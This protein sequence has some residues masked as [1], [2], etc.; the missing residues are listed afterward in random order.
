[1]PNENAPPQDVEMRDG[2]AAADYNAST[3]KVLHGLEAVRKRPGMYIGDTDDGTGLH[4]MVFE[5]VDNAIDEALA[6]WCD[7]IGLTI[8]EDGSITV[9]DNGRGIP[10]D[11]NEA[12]QK[13]GV[14]IVFT[15]LHG[16]GKFDQ[17]SYKVSGGLHGVGASV[18][19][20]LSSRLEVEVCRDGKMYR[21]AFADGDVVEPLSEVAEADGKRGTKVTFWPS[22]DIFAHTEFDAQTL[23]RRL[24]ELAL[25][26]SADPVT[27]QPGVR[28]VF[29]DAREPNFEP[30]D[31]HYEGGL[32]T[33]VEHLDVGNKPLISAPVLARG[34]RDTQVGKD[35][36]P[37]VSIFVDVA[38][39]W[40]DGVREN[41]VAFTNNIPQRDGGTH[42]TGFRAALTRCM[43][44]FADSVYKDSKK[45]PKLAAED[46]REG[47]TAVVSVKMPDPKFSSQTKEK[48]VSSEVTTPVTQVIVEVLNTWLEENPSD[49][50]AVLAK[51]VEA[52]DAREAARRARELTKRKSVLDIN[53]MPG[54]LA[55]CQSKNPEE[56]ELFI[57]EGDSAGGSAKQ[58]RDRKYQAILPLRG[59]ILNTERARLAKILKN[60]LV[61]TLI[62]A[63][64]CGIGEDGYDPEK[65]RYHKIIIMTDADVDGSH[66]A[67]LLLTF[68][69][70]YMPELVERGHIYIAQPPLFG[71]QKGKSDKV[72]L[73]DIPARDEYLLG[74]GSAGVSAVA[75]DGTQITGDDLKAL[76]LEAGD[77]KSQVEEVNTQIGCLPLAA[78][79][80]VSGAFHP[81]AFQSEEN[82]RSTGEFLCS[83]M[84]DRMPGTKWSYDVTAEGLQFTY[85][86]RGVHNEVLVPVEISR[87]KAATAL[88]R[89][90]ARLS[91]IY[92]KGLKIEGVD[93]PFYT[94]GDLYE[95]VLKKG[96]KG[97]SISRYKGLGEMSDDQL[98]ETTLCP[99]NRT[100]LQ[101][102]VPMAEEANATFQTLMGDVVP[103]R[104]QFIEENALLVENLDV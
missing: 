104:R 4:H 51:I 56:S 37:E 58:G 75:A 47:L 95:W 85:R 1:M 62:K 10:C 44:A 25:L 80:A 19:N 3:L 66:I 23:L 94:P 11:W 83:Q 18:V 32:A 92:L 67:T 99:D 98:W 20:A 79:F 57:V 12:E 15:E 64:G 34:E 53:S 49:A 38:F 71:V 61:G 63:L 40:T 87:H 91:E 16:G 5:I 27:G 90:H 21:M 76:A 22:A 36:R 93:S 43:M 68:F 89:S 24:R 52:A 42:I 35:G 70:R 28:I 81:A 86:E 77:L 46:I 82:M 84:P 8:N 33:F 73:L 101:V 9:S 50:K 103:P 17:N 26:N 78:A 88:A 29:T 13:T 69:F 41:V 55:D 54:K 14:E 72:Y 30:V 2:S 65:L 31:L 39:Q 48:L 102:K 97:V 60:D 74:L 96:S 45:K 6:G 100:L 59:K 7:K